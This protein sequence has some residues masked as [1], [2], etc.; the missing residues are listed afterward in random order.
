MNHKGAGCSINGKNYELKIYNIL[1]KCKLDQQEFDI[2][3][4][5]QQENELGGCG[6]DNDIIC[7]YINSESQQIIPIPIEIKKRKTPDWMQC[8]LKYC[9]NKWIGSSKNKIPEKSKLIF[10]EILSNTILFNGN[11]PPFME[12]DITHEEWIHIKKNTFDFNDIYI[13]CPDDTIKRLY[14]EKGCVYIQI[15][16]KGLYHLGDDICQF[17]VPEFICPQQLRIRTKIHTRKNTKGF[18]KLS[19]IIACQPKNINNIIASNYSLD[20]VLKLP[21]NLIYYS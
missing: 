12:K 21:P 2:S 10:E 5:T 14:R 19:V 4:N 7:S 8:S 3:F 17:N 11:I 13:D 20:N 9:S 15:S 6:A 1:K 16:D 18:C